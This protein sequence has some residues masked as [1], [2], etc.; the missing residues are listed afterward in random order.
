[1]TITKHENLKILDKYKNFIRVTNPITGKVLFEREN[2]V[3]QRG[4][5]FTLEKVFN[6]F[7]THGDQSSS[8]FN[9]NYYKAYAGDRTSY[10]T[11]DVNESIPIYTS[12]NDNYILL[13]DDDSWNELLGDRSSYVAGQSNDGVSVYTYDSGS[14]TYMLL[15]GTTTPTRATA[16]AQVEPFTDILYL[17]DPKRVTVL[18]E[19]PHETDIFLYNSQVDFN[20]KEVVLFKVG[21]GG[22]TGNPLEP[23]APS[24]T[25]SELNNPVP[26]RTIPTNIDLTDYS[27]K[28]CLKTSDVGS[29]PLITFDTW[30][31]KL[32]ENID[33]IWVIDKDRN[34][35]AKK[36]ELKIDTNDLR[37]VRE[38]DVVIHRS[39]AE[40]RG[41]V[42]KFATEKGLCRSVAYSG[43]EAYYDGAGAGL[44][45]GTID[46]LGVLSGHH[47]KMT[48]TVSATTY[49]FEVSLEN[50]VLAA[51]NYVVLN[52]V[53]SFNFVDFA[54]NGPFEILHVENADTLIGYVN[55]RENM[56]ISL[57]HKGD[58]VR[59]DDLLGTDLIYEVLT[60][61]VDI[62]STG[63]KIKPNLSSVKDVT[64]TTST[65]TGTR[66]FD[67]GDNLIGVVDVQSYYEYFAMF[68]ELGLY[69]AEVDEATGKV[70]DGS[71]E[72]FSI[73][74]FASKSLED[75][76]EILFEYYIYA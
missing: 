61:T 45:P 36:L 59:Y 22:T 12:I 3:V 15:D 27:N 60:E 63:F 64:T 72:L 43:N 68:N 70:V 69:I 56:D 76:E 41:N 29:N 42:T 4:R 28:Y 11:G 23:L 13:D 57:L 14:N 9:L 73:I 25:S 74:T 34:I 2:M 7:Y 17:M 21:T 47:I 40:M 46:M 75:T 51:S 33:P 38:G 16:V 39:D 65:F 8:M 18:L 5:L 44:T 1:M 55:I 58:E 53:D 62:L 26:F 67:S 37:D 66:L 50:D 31:G 30:Y 54:T 10:Q 32:F 24:A 6:D 52:E 19:S 48:D 49:T 20:K 71:E 35:I